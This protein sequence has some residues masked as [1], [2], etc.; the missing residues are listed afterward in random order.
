MTWSRSTGLSCGLTATGC[1]AR[2]RTRGAY[3]PAVID[4]LTLSPA[5]GKISAVTAFVLLDEQADPAAVFARFGLPATA[6]AS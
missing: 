1:S 6:P 5:D 3:E 2:S 4:V